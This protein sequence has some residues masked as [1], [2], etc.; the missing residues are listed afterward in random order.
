MCL[1]WLIPEEKGQCDAFAERGTQ[2]TVE[3]FRS[4]QQQHCKWS[5]ALTTCRVG[6]GKLTAQEVVETCVPWDCAVRLTGVMQEGRQASAAVSS[7]SPRSENSAGLE[8]SSTAEKA[9]PT[10]M[11]CFLQC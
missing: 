5:P 2:T 9:V 10:R 11:P 8:G 1:R 6:G 3:Q 7:V 4:C